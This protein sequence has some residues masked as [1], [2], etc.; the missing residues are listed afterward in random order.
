LVVEVD[1]TVALY[2]YI[3]TS[4]MKGYRRHSTA[5]LSQVATSIV[6]VEMAGG[7]ILDM[8]V[9]TRDLVDF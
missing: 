8:V 2:D 3:S 9:G 6:M 4:K 7:G 1:A 5:L